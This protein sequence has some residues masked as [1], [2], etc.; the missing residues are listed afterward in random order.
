[1]ETERAGRQRSQRTTV[2][3]GAG[4]NLPLAIV[5][6]ASLAVVFLGALTIGAYVFLTFIAILVVVAQIELDH[7]F[8]V[9]GLNPATPVAVGA[10]L[11]MLYG[12]YVSGPAAQTV[13]IVAL[14]LGAMVWTLLDSRRHDVAFSL[15]AT[16]LGGLWVPFLASYIALLLR[17]GERFGDGRVLVAVVIALT[18]AN[19][20][21]AYAFGNRLGRH[22]MAPNVSPGKTWEGFAGGLVTVLGVAGL[23]VTRVV[24]ELGVLGALVLG[25]GVV[26]A[27]TLGD[28][29]ESLVKRDLGIKDLG[30]ILPGHG[31]VMDRVDAMLFTLPVA[32]GILV[33]LGL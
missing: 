30:R 2:R 29:S 26:A 7:A 11:V 17:G 3:R 25:A 8:R 31:G 12:A 18:V 20:I 24:P 16:F 10:G 32:Y 15:G 1:V 6:G 4:R 21:G 28:L 9:H 27:A 14:V 19:D 23:G 5:V 13:G 22:K 33:A